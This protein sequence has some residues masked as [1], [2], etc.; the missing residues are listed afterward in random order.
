MT[1]VLWG[2][3]AAIV[4]IGALAVVLLVSVF[5]PVSIVV[6]RPDHKPEWLNDA[7][8]DRM[9]NERI[10]AEQALGRQP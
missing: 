2:L 7:D 10:A 3:G 6:D 9:T 4:V 8:L 1:S 5:R